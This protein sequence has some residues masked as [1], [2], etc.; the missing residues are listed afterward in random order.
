MLLNNAHD[1]EY[2]LVGLIRL[3]FPLSVGGSL[4]DIGLGASLTSAFV[5]A[6][7]IGGISA[8]R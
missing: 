6:W 8:L 2:Q 5:G 4:L 3:P 1:D 7:Y